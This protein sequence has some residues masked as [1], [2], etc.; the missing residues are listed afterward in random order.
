MVF[1]SPSWVPQLPFDPPDTAT[2]PDF[3]FNEQYGR[4]A[5]DKSYAPFT[6]GLSGREY[7]PRELH[8]R[9]EHL[10]SGLAKELGW[11]PNQ[12]T[13]WDKVVGILSTNTVSCL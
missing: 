7:L 2:L 8:Q 9:V 11:K 12:G 13:E 5:M 6:C 4:M 3:M 10:A 1:T